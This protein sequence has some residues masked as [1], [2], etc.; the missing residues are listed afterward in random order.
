MDV[1]IYE[2]ILYKIVVYFRL[3][4]LEENLIN[5]MDVYRRV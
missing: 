3:C 5:P 1:M 4:A 2:A